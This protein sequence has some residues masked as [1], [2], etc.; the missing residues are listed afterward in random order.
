MQQEG[1][2]AEAGSQLRTLSLLTDRTTSSSLI[3]ADAV[4]RRRCWEQQSTH[5]NR[6]RRGGLSASTCQLHDALGNIAR[7]LG[8]SGTKWLANDL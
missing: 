3:S 5:F 1:R 8:T 7:H 6:D 4:P 2:K